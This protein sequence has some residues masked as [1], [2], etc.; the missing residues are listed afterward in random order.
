MDLRLFI[1]KDSL[2]DISKISGDYQR[3]DN[4]EGLGEEFSFTLALNKKD[5]EWPGFTVEMG[6]KVIFVN[7]GNGKPIL[8]SEGEPIT[9]GAKAGSFLVLAYNSD[10]ESWYQIGGSGSKCSVTSDMPLH[11]G[12]DENGVYV[13]TED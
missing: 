7:G 4:S 9:A 12:I 1:V 3:S 13:I 5:K 11:F 10:A 8:T 6:D 2:V